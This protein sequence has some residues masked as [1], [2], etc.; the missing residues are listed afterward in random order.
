MYAIAIVR[1][2]RPLDE[3]IAHQDPHRAYLRELKARGTLLAAG[4][5]DPRYGGIFLLRIPDEH[6]QAA[7][8]AIRDGDPFYQQGVAQYEL[9]PWKPVIGVD[10]LDRL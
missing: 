4:P 9:L 5:Q 6:P 8:D 7:L 10:D 1:Y 2:R 3:V